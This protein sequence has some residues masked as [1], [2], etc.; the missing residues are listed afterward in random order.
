MPERVTVEDLAAVLHEPT[1]VLL[2]R[3]LRTLGEHRC[4]AI[5]AETLTI[6]S[7]GGMLTRAGDRRRTPGGVFLELVRAQATASERR[8]IFR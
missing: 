2:A 3:V 8:A 7:N 5:L 6:E 4:V 1:R